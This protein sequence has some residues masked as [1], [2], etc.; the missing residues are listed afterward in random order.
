M[1]FLFFSQRTSLMS[2]GCARVSLRNA[3]PFFYAIKNILK[4]KARANGTKQ[5]FKNVTNSMLSPQ[6]VM[7]NLINC[8]HHV[9]QKTSFLSIVERQDKMLRGKRKLF[10]SS[11][12][13]YCK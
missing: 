11:L 13:N 1:H 7:A 10:L 5:E 12:A 8:S 9:K 2:G 6:A 4:K 3:E